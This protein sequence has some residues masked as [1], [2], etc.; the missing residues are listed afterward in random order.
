MARDVFEKD[1]FQPITEFADD[2]G[3]VGP[4]V[5]RIICPL[6][7]SGHAERLAWI[8]GKHGVKG[9]SERL[10]VECGKIIPYGR[11]GKVSGALCCDDGASW[12]FFPFDKASCVEVW[13]GQHEAHIKAT[14]PGAEGQSVS[15]RKHHVMQPRPV[16]PRIARQR[17][18]AGDPCFRGRRRNLALRGRRLHQVTSAP[19]PTPST[20]PAPCP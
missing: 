19:N 11:W 13:F 10:G 5:A 14:G 3:D 8:S 18:A 6:A 2:A 15:G 7:L 16:A 4:E 9:A 12:V 20:C 17:S 1:P